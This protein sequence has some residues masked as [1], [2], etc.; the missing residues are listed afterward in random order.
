MSATEIEGEIVNEETRHLPAVIEGASLTV[1]PQVQAGELVARL[2][3]IE[4]AMRTAMVPGVDYGVIPGTDKPALLKPGSE[5]LGALFQLDV[6][7]ENEKIWHDDGHLTVISKA[8]VWHQP[9]GTR[10]GAGE[11]LCTTR[12]SRYAS[13]NA[14]RRCPACGVEAIIKGKQE[15]GGGWVCFKKKNGCGAKYAD[16]DQA[17]TS[18]AVGKIPNPDLADTY[19]TVDK[20][21]SKRARVDA[22]LSVT[23]A[24]A[25]FTQDVEDA[26]APEPVSSSGGDVHGLQ[27]ARADS[28]SRADRMRERIYVLASEA[29]A[30][31]DVA[32]GTS[33]AEILAKLGDGANDEEQLGF[34]GSDVAEWIAE[35]CKQPFPDFE[36]TPF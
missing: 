14:S 31:R 19:N 32:A 16:D 34:I 20:M 26:A 29:D 27:T 30:K 15:Y 21:A 9:T 7:L 25:L 6:Q 24:S 1:T 12:E 35:G 2:A 3:V 17:I 5:K 33:R 18:Q 22:V 8:I 11:G 13:R 4:E 10:L 36:P 23:G 28:L